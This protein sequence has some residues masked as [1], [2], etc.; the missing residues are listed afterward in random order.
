MARADN[1]LEERQLIDVPDLDD[2]STGTASDTIADS[3]AAYNQANQNAFRASMAKKM[4]DILD[5]LRKL[6]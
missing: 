3:G 1:T 5:R 6:G 4:N 2:Q